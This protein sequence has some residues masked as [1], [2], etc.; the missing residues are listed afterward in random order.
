MIIFWNVDA[1]EPQCLAIIVTNIG[2]S[3]MYVKILWNFCASK[4]TQSCV[5]TTFAYM[6]P[7]PSWYNNYFCEHKPTF[8]PSMN[9]STFNDN[10]EFNRLPKNWKS[11]LS[12][13]SS[14]LT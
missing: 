14:R 3:Y 1:F 8:N 5:R 12:K 10:H 4:H 7:A 2:V 9:T 6:R 13:Y 11:I